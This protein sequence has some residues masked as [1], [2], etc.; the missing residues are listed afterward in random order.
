[1]SK[2]HKIINGLVFREE[3]AF[4]P[5]TVYLCGDRIVSE[6]AYS[7]SD[8]DET[9]TDAEGCYVI[10]GLTDIH[11]HGSLRSTSCARASLPSLPLP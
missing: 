11:F 3:G 5:A 7:A 8:A 10:P 6:E 4:E 9:I 1:M 2:K